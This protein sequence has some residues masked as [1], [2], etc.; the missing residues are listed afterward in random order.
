MNFFQAALLVLLYIIA[1]AVVGAA[2][3]A[4]LN[5]LG[6]VPRMAQALRVRMPSNA[7]GGC[8]ALG[9]FALS[10]LSLYMPH[11][12]LAPAFGALPGL[13]LG[14]FVGILAAALAESLEFISLGIRRLRMMNTAR[15][16]IGGII[17]G[18]LAAS[19]LFWLYPLY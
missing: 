10:L 8:I 19:L 4:L 11:W 1:G 2:L 7:W 9:A 3:G 13:M 14:I 6:V 5:L 15:Y 17:L 18:K 16:L 12:N